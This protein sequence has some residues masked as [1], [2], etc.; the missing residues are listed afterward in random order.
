MGRQDWEAEDEPSEEEEP[1]CT[2]TQLKMFLTLVFMIFPIFTMFFHQFFLYTDNIPKEKEG[3]VFIQKG[4][5]STLAF[6]MTI[7]I[8]S[9]PYVKRMVDISFLFAF[10]LSF[11]VSSLTLNSHLKKN[12]NFIYF[13]SLFLFTFSKAIMYGLILK[14][15]IPYTNYFRYFSLSKKIPYKFR[16]DVHPSVHLISVGEAD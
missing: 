5:L 14:Y 3:V 12:N 11:S 10:T 4:L 8:I 15:V 13:F 2:R 9:V 16:F 6:A 7:P 1:I